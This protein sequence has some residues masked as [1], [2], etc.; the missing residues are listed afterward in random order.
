MQ[1]FEGINQIQ[2]LVVSRDLAKGYPAESRPPDSRQHRNAG[3]RKQTSR[4]DAIA[5]TGRSISVTHVSR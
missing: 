1:I 4:C 5:A 2:R 3:A